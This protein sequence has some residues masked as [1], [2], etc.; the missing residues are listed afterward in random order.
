M[1]ERGI[2]R[3][4]SGTAVEM[5]LINDIAD[6]VIKQIKSKLPEEARTYDTAKYILRI[7]NEKIEGSKM[8]YKE[9]RCIFWSV[10]AIILNSLRK[11]DRRWDKY[12]D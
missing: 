12:K 2:L 1:M 3:T 11:L 10:S 5:S 4:I 8:D 6:E 7:A 9:W